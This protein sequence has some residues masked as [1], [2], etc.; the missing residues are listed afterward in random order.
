MHPLLR[1]ILVAGLCAGSSLRVHSQDFTNQ[2]F[3]TL[4]LEE[5]MN[6]KITVASIKELTPRQSPGI[7]TYITAEDIRNMGARDLME[8]LRQVPGFEFGADVEGI[9][10]LAVRGNW[11]H[12]GKA[13]LFIDGVEMN[14]SLY[15]TLQFGNHYPVENI[16]RI[17]IIRGPGSALHGGFAAYAVINII[18]RN[19]RQKSEISATANHSFT[20]EGAARRT[21]SVYTGHSVNNTAFTVNLKASS[22]QRSQDTY[23][24]VY[25]SSYP[26]DQQS[27]IRNY[28]LNAG[29]KIGNLYLRLISDHYQVESRDEYVEIGAAANEMNFTHTTFDT[30]YEWKR[31][32]RFKLI[33]GLQLT[34]Q[35]PWSTPKKNMESDNEPFR[36]NSIS[37]QALVNSSYD[38]SDELN[39]TGGISWNSLQSKKELEDDV[40]QTTG[41]NEFTNENLAAYA[42]LLFAASW[43]NLIAGV[44]FNHNK[45]YENAIVPRIGIT[46]EFEKFHVKAL[47]SRAFRAPGTQNIDLSESIQPEYT[48]VY[49]LEGGTKIST[50]IY[51]TVNAFYIST[52]DPIVYYFDTLSNV[53]AYTNFKST[54]TKGIESVLM[55]KKKWGS[56]HFNASVYSANGNNSI[57]IYNVPGNEGLHLGLAR[58][59]GNLSFNY[60]VLPNLEAG[61]QYH[62]LSKRYGITTYDDI[63][64]ETGYH[65]YPD[66]HLLHT[67]LEYRFKKIKGLGL[68][69]CVKNVLDQ[70]EWFI[71][72]YNS[73]HAA[74][75]GMKREF[76]IRI[77]YQNF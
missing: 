73:N 50:D 16:E 9:V 49:E 26:M 43:A 60:R 5:L 59:K 36:I 20:A 31:G 64:Q 33:P 39:L 75:P 17:E 23:T 56:I 68:G 42:Q 12:E 47:F 70:E 41:T 35:R 52:M 29:G 11:A 1:F 65:P 27:D 58:Y 46:R 32:D 38:F 55:L 10:G 3:D 74:L 44:R 28:S 45:R 2:N 40:F 77:S 13:V 51:L 54:G 7:I 76:Q 53:D 21:A 15:S 19:P 14:E 34:Q 6:I 63:S 67:Q 62:Y 18:T 66:F 8:V 57:D 48:N 25:G 69:I 72:P 24:D 4:S 61:I 22:S 71:Q 30:K 37:C